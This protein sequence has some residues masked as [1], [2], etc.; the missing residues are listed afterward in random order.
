MLTN[1]YC[2]VTNEA[3]ENFY[4]VF[5]GELAGD[6]PM[7]KTSIANNSILIGLHCAGNKNGILVPQDTNDQEFQH[8]RNNLPDKVVVQRIDEGPFYLR[9]YI[10]CNDHI[11]LTQRDLNCEAEE[12]IG[13]V[14]GVD[15]F[16]QTVD[17]EVFVGDYCSFTNNGGLVPPHTSFKELEELSVLL[18]VPLVTGTVNGGRRTISGG[19]IV[20]D[21]TAFCGSA[22]TDTELSV[23]ESVF[24]L[25]KAQPSMIVGEMRKLRIDSYV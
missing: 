15:V 25:N 8:L 6:I 23:I 19:M 16:K 24:K 4:S 3:S 1:A 18:Q 12:L 7:V 11:A 13:D 17:G 20:N 9:R 10:S 2:L 5:E 14:L 21:W 22:T